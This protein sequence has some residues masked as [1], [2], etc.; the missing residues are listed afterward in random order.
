MLSLQIITVLK[1]PRSIVN[2]LNA[3]GLRL[4][5]LTIFVVLNSSQDLD[6]KSKL[7]STFILNC[8]TRVTLH[9]LN[10]GSCCLSHL[11]SLTQS[12]ISSE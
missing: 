4:F 5:I 12:P 9:S 10:T 11:L 7:I 2:E 8:V 6:I 1:N 3:R